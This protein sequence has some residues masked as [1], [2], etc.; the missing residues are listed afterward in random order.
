[1]GR[2]GAG[3]ITRHLM[4][5]AGWAPW[6]V[7][8]S[9]ALWCVGPVAVASP[10]V[11][12]PAA[13]EQIQQ[14]FREAGPH[15]RLE[16]ASLSPDQVRATVCGGPQDAPACGTVVLSDPQP[17]C[18][19]T[20]AGPWCVTFPGQELPDDAR[21]ALLQALGRPIASPW[22]TMRRAGSVGSLPGAGPY[23][24]F[25][26]GDLGK[27]AS[28]IWWNGVFPPLLWCILVLLLA[29]VL[30]DPGRPDGRVS[31]ARAGPSDLWVLPA[32]FGVAL[33][34][35]LWLAWAGPIN[36]VEIERIPLYTRHDWYR[37]AAA[38]GAPLAWLLGDPVKAQQWTSLG[39]SAATVGLAGLL[40]IRWWGRA[41][42]WA[43]GLLLAFA[44]DAIRWSRTLDAGV[45]AA[46]LAVLAVLATEAFRQRPG[47]RAALAAGVAWILLVLSRPEA[48]LMLVPL[49][50]W[51]L[52]E[53]ER[54]VRAR[55]SAVVTFAALVWLGLVL[56]VTLD[57]TS[58][59]VIPVEWRSLR[60]LAGTYAVQA[61]RLVLDP[62]SHDVSTLVL[63]L[64]G[65]F[66][67]RGRGRLVGLLVGL[68][69][70]PLGP[71]IVGN[72]DLLLHNERYA[73][74]GGVFVCLLA[75]ATVARGR[76]WLA[77]RVT[78]AQATVG[79]VVV[80]ALVAVIGTATRIWLPDP[81]QAQYAF[82]ARA[83]PDLPGNSRVW[84]AGGLDE[85]GDRDLIFPL[86]RA[87]RGEPSRSGTACPEDGRIQVRF[88]PDPSRRRIPEGCSLLWFRGAWAMASVSARQAEQ[89]L[90]DS[91]WRLEPVRVEHVPVRDP[92]HGR[93]ATMEIGFWRL[94]APGAG[95]SPGGDP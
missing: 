20:V 81:L 9:V 11:L 31:E 33:A 76:A 28:D 8:G 5:T 65:V 69:L 57:A 86:E 62:A 72:R 73:L 80:V 71:A 54:W 78:P 37:V 30:R 14:V 45:V 90:R 68:V 82:L 94:S 26:P 35:R 34:L 87:G 40:G 12:M 36:F 70:T 7:C 77:G 64:G 15:V 84:F 25:R 95:S 55:K 29:S 60:G 21:G 23:R 17:A 1:M 91:G 49:G 58:S 38:W 39:F 3:L 42:G 22:A 6:V 92:T 75:G 13:A 52:V 66:L 46:F 59:P 32:L 41:G 44:P 88:L 93:P 43:A 18:K 27:S 79:L 74:V 47:R 56:R 67:G 2:A 53:R 24:A 89:Q 48:A 4:Q 19:G 51:A 83:V 61:Y 85:P 63:A 10:R 16:G 50:I